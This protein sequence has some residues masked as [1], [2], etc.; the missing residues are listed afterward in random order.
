MGDITRYPKHRQVVGAEVPN[1]LTAGSDVNDSEWSGSVVAFADLNAQVPAGGTVIT[2]CVDDDRKVR[3]NRRTGRYFFRRI[4]WQARLDGIVVVVCERDLMPQPDGRFKPK[5]GWR[6]ISTHDHRSDGSVKNRTGDVVDDSANPA[7]PS[8]QPSTSAGHDASV[9]KSD[10]DLEYL[11][12]AVRLGV[13]KLVPS[14]SYFHCQA[15]QYSVDGQP[16]HH[17]VSVLRLSTTGAV[18]VLASR[19]MNAGTWQVQQVHYGLKAPA[20]PHEGS[21]MPR[22]P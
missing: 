22:L 3:R 5:G 15:V 2:D 9:T 17:R 10:R 1:K 6:V 4:G 7:I 18:V 13:V 8:R 16:T 12:R 11:P 20:D 19:Q 14:P 21:R